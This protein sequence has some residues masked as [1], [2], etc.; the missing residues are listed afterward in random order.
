MSGNDTGPVFGTPV[1]RHGSKYDTVVTV[2]PQAGKP[3]V[4]AAILRRRRALTTQQRL[5]D[6]E[7]LTRRLSELPCNG[8]VVCA[9]V[10]IGTE[11]GSPAMLDA[12]VT[13]GAQV[14][15]PVTRVDTPLSWGWYQPG[16][17]IEAQFGLLEPDAAHLPPEAIGQASVVLVPA[18]CVDR[19]GVRL[20]RGAGYYDRSLSLATPEAL[21]VA[22]VYDDELLPEL[23]AEP[24]DVAMTHALT[25]GSGLVK[26]GI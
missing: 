1:Q 22:V 17:L 21:L 20:G 18:L 3:E 10:P 13:A 19:A 14:L 5:A 4:R 26:L 25:P 12:L 8:A 2:S 24:H 16:R 15:L 11:P 23:P 6:A 7:A 9:Y